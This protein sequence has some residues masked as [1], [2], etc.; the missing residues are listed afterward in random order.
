MI[1]F[2]QVEN[3]RRAIQDTVF[4]VILGIL[5]IS[6]LMSIMFWLTWNDIIQMKPLIRGFVS[7]IFFVVSYYTCKKIFH[8]IHKIYYRVY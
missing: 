6:G 8:Q 1:D 2:D 3:S 4:V 5:F 7:F